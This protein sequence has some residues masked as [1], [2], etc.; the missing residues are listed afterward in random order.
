MSP[1]LETSDL[2]TYYIRDTKSVSQTCINIL[3]CHKK[4]DR[5]SWE[6]ETEPLQHEL[7]STL[8]VSFE[9]G[10]HWHVDFS[11]VGAKRREI[12]GI[13]HMY[14]PLS[15]ETCYMD[16]NWPAFSCVTAFKEIISFCFEPG[17]KFHAN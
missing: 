1:K 5:N 12:F 6:I 13:S 16:K 3:F 11:F 10:S 2:K 7:F 14:L 15:E 9:N 4:Y 8:S 17:Q